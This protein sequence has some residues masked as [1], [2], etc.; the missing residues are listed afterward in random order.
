[1]AG[2][3]SVTD[4][5]LSDLSPLA[6]YL[7][8]A[9]GIMLGAIF[10]VGR[11][12]N[13]LIFGTQP[14]TA[15]PLCGIVTG[16][17]M[18][19]LVIVNP[20]A[21]RAEIAAKELSQWFST[22]ATAIFVRATSID[23]LKQTLHDHGMNAERIVIGGGDGTISAALPEL[24]R[25]GKPLAVLPLGTANDFA[26]NLGVP[27]DANAAAET[28]LGGR[29]HR[30][31]VGK[32]NGRPFINVASV[33]LAAKVTE[34]QSSRLK[35][36]WRVFSYL[37]SLWRAIWAARP[38]YLELELDGAPAWSGAVYQV[39]VGNGR[40]HGGG[41]T[42]S[43]GA[44]IDDGKFDLY[45]VCPGAAWQLLAA[46]THLRFGLAKPDLLKQSSAT[47]VTLRTATPRAINVDGELD[48]A[49]PAAFELLPGALTLIVPRTLPAGHRGLS[50]LP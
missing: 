45:F 18:H 12:S 36:R 26:R 37:I 28:A 40:F 27:D 8:T 22:H 49:T 4:Q 15:R 33:G 19:V 20:E 7:S 31:D 42:V 2:W 24:L 17:A 16:E 6:T 1:M 38:F 29:E 25:L 46:A 13:P 39:S 23:Q 9:P 3:D 44:A 47:R 11:S 50:K 41:L 14:Y 35:R 34:E 5:W 48:G 21:S 32:V 30:I 43:E 10:L